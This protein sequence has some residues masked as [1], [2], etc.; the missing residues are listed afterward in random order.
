MERYRKEIEECTTTY[1][2]SAYMQV[3]GTKVQFTIHKTNGEYRLV[4][5][6]EETYYM[7][8]NQFKVFPTTNSKNVSFFDK[9]GYDSF[10]NVLLEY[11][12]LVDAVQSRDACQNFQKEFILDDQYDGN[13]ILS[14]CKVCFTDDFADQRCHTCGF[15]V[16]QFCLYKLSYLSNEYSCPQCKAKYESEDYENY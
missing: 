4:G 5:S 9:K 2:W 7:H 15:A 16:C 8:A 3:F 14:E 13:I 6:F 1:C 10:D 11:N 12:R